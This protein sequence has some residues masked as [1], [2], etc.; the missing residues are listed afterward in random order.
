MVKGKRPIC[1]RS[2]RRQR[3]RTMAA[4]HGPSL[5]SS[6]PF[7]QTIDVPAGWSRFSSLARW[8]EPKPATVFVSLPMRILSPTVNPL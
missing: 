3:K 7:L 5:R 6:Q 4:T 2:Y 8:M 1:E